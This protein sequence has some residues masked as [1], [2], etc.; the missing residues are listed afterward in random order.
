MYAMRERYACCRWPGS[1]K[2]LDLHEVPI[3]MSHLFSSGHSMTQVALCVRQS[4]FK[5]AEI[6]DVPQALALSTAG[7]GLLSDF[8]DNSNGSLIGE[9][10]F[11]HNNP[12]PSKSAEDSKM[13]PTSRHLG[14]LSPYPPSQKGNVGNRIV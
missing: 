7:S 3:P 12:N 14:P 11:A 2:Y 6:A 8:K 9:T 13:S 10:Q 5:D 4:S 1:K